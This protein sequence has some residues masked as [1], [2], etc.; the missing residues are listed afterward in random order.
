MHEV[1]DPQQ[2]LDAVWSLCDGATVTHFNVPNA[3]SF[4]RLLAVE[5]GLISQA[6][7]ASE[8]DRVFGNVSRFERTQFIELL[9]HAGFRVAESGT[10]FLKPVSHDQMDNV[11]ATLG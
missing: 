3:L 7:E 8:R 11:L 6:S 2:L 4:H 1:P 9:E 10:Y 5:M